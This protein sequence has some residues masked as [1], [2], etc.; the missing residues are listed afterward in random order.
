MIIHC[1]HG[2]DGNSEN[3]RHRLNIVLMLAQRR[4]RCASI[5]TT[6]VNVS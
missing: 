4:R 2:R 5:K 3:T 1:T 6:L